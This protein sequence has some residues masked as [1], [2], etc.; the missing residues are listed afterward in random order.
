MIVKRMVDVDEL[1]QAAAKMCARYCKYPL[2]W[3]EDAM[4]HELSDSEICRF[5]PMSELLKGV[6]IENLSLGRNEVAE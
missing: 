6:V 3:D 2:I 1:E 5:C 4:N